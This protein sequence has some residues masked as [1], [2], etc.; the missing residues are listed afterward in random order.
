MTEP[1]PHTAEIVDDTPERRAAPRETSA[2]GATR[3]VAG[4]LRRLLHE[5]ADESDRGVPVGAR[6]RAASALL[7]DL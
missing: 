7:N 6:L 5:L 4:Q 2:T 1:H 3:D